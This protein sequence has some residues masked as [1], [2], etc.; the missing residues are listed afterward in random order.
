MTGAAYGYMLRADLW[1]AASDLKDKQIQISTKIT[2]E[3]L[4]A[5]QNNFFDNIQLTAVFVIRKKY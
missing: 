3:A 1:H 2:S 5:L 4:N